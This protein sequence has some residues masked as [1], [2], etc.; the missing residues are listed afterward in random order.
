MLADDEFDPRRVLVVD[1]DGPMLRTHARVL[2]AHGLH[3]VVMADAAEALAE[4]MQR[5]PAVLVVDLVMPGMSGLELVTR[6]RA[7]FGRS[8]PPVVLVSA[9]H[10]QLAPIEQLMF[11]AIVTKPFS[12]DRLVQVTKRLARQHADRRQAPSGVRSKATPA[13]GEGSES[14]GS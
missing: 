12:I 3:P 7:H 11:D 2:E 9:N 1:D 5:V 4:A 10:V 14:E 8:C 6:L 13:A